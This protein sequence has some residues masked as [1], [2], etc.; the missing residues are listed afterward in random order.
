MNSTHLKLL[1]VGATGSV[2]RLVLAEA[3]RNGHTVRALVRDL[4]RMGS[5]PAGVQAVRGDLTRTDTLEAAVEGIAAIVFT[6]GSGS[7]G[8]TGAEQ[9]DYG[10]VR[11]VLQALKG[12][13]VRIAL[14][15]TIGVTD[16]L[17][18]YNRATEAHDW[19]RRGERLVRASGLRYTIVRP[20]WFDYNAGNQHRLVLLQ[21]DTRH[22]GDPSDGVV[23][24]RQIAQVLVHSLT[25]PAATNKT[26]ELVAED[27]AATVDFE[28]A[29]AAL[30]A[31]HVGALDAVRD[32]PNMPPA[33]E[34]DRVQVDM[35]RLANQ[36]RPGVSA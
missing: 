28:V 32:A 6:H 18:S 34:P 36:A 27:G 31:D 10:G 7:D 1:V 8:K 4:N 33:N 30:D 14:M 26:F 3:I 21:G 23:S 22:A 16:R 9:V 25:S 12:R 5:M 35:S 29:F 17:G 11:N 2:G 24:R 15:T 13:Q 20:G 19:K